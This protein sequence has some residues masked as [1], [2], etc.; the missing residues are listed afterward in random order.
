[1]DQILLELGKNVCLDDILSAVVGPKIKSQGQSLI[2]Q[3]PLCAEYLLHDI[4]NLFLSKIK[5]GSL[6][7]LIKILFAL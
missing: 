5:D 3:S 7:I 4:P 6:F 1:M 2:R